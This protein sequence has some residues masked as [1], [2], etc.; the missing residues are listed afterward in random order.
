MRFRRALALG[1]TTLAAIAGVLTGPVAPAQAAA[2]A[3]TAVAVTLANTIALNNCSA[4]LVRFPTSV[5]T[6]SAMMLTNGHCYEGGFIA[7]GRVIQNVSSTRTGTLLNSSGGSVARVRANRVIYATMTGNDVAL[8]RLNTTF[9][10]LS[11]SYGAVPLT[12]SAAHPAA[13]T[14]IGIPSGYWKR[15]W[16]CSIDGFVTTLREDTWTWKD[17]VRYNAGCDT[18]GGTSGSP[19]VS[20]ATGELIG[21]NNTGNESGGRCTLNNPCEVSASG[22]VTVLQGRSYG[23]QTYWFTTCLSATRT[24]DLTVSGCLLTKP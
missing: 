10:A 5:G 7:A 18:I 19:I 3:P 17:S 8:Y 15:V 11:S 13:G 23:Q 14:S 21:I 24:I 4:S 1:A 6:D 22:V 9:A 12:I 20:T 2:P 16:N